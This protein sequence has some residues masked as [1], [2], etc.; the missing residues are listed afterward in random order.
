M[1][2]GAGEHEKWER[3]FRYIG[4][5]DLNEGQKYLA[6]DVKAIIEGWSKH[7][8]RAE[9]CRV[10]LLMD[11]SPAPVQTAKEVY[12]CPQ[13]AARQ[14]F[15]EFQ[16]LGRPFRFL[17]DPVKL[18]DVPGMAGRPPPLLGQHNDY[19]FGELLGM[20]REQIQAMKTN[21]AL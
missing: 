18:S 17:G 20:S 6:V 4:R 21:G 9:V 7:L 5:S 13:L 2:S 11:F 14:M 8:P 1:I 16:H 12:D 15:V 19:V 10:L 3:M